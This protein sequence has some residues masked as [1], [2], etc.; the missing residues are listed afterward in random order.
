MSEGYAIDAVPDGIVGIVVRLDGERG[1]RFHSA[2][3]A[4]DALNGHVFVS[5]A[6]AQ[7]AAHALLRDGRRPA[8]SRH[9]GKRAA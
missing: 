5:P 4:Y 2:T 3:K 9:F 1:F 6:A 8:A 7:K